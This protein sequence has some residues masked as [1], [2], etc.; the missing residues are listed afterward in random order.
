MKGTK[1]QQVTRSHKSP[2]SGLTLHSVENG[3]FQCLQKPVREVLG[4]ITET[5][6]NSKA[7]QAASYTL[8]MNES[9]SSGTC[10]GPVDSARI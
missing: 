1:K 5:L 10:P 3:K 2:S 8:K 7:I 6:H 4:A 9:A